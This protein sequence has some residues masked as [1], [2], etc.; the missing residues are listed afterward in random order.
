MGILALCV[1]L[2]Q[3][4]VKCL[5]CRRNFSVDGEKWS[6][7]NMTHDEEADDLHL[8]GSAGADVKLTE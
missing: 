3:T 5:V 6:C 2:E 4:N 8:S 1:F 7:S